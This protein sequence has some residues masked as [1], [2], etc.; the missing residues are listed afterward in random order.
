MIA[1]EVVQQHCSTIIVRSDSG[2]RLYDM[3]R[4]VFWLT[5]PNDRH[6]TDRR[7]QRQ[8]L[9]MP[10]IFTHKYVFSDEIPALLQ[11]CHTLR[12][13]GRDA[14]YKVASAKLAHAETKNNVDRDYRKYLANDYTLTY[15][16]NSFEKLSGGPITATDEMVM[17]AWYRMQRQGVEMVCNALRWHALRRVC[18]MLELD[19]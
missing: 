12:G 7:T 8:V 1:H 6:A 2:E 17:A 3:W 13:E 15:V 5:D 4:Q 10:N 16:L 11:V 18:K 14:Y 19:P 9:R